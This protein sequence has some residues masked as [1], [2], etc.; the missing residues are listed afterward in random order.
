MDAKRIGFVSTRLAG[1]DGVS[2]ETDK[3]SEIFEE[4]GHECYYMAGE[5]DTHPDRSF[6]VP[7]CHFMHPEIVSLYRACFDHDVRSPATTLE[8]ERIKHLLKGRL[9]AFVERFELDLLVPENAVTIPLNLPLGL[10]IAEYA[11]ETGMPMIAHHHDF[12]WERKR[13][14]RNAAWDY[15]NTAFPPHLPSLQHAVLNSS[16]DNQ[17]SLRTGIS[18]HVVPNVMDFA[19]PPVVADDFADD[20]RATL[21]IEPREKLILQP[22]RIVPRKGIEHAIELVHRLRM[23][24]KLVITHAAGDEGD[25]YAERVREYAALLKVAVVFCSDRVGEHRGIDAAGRKT[26]SLGDLYRQC[27]LVTYPSLIEGFGNAF[28]EAV[29]YRR[30]LMVNNYSIYH[31]DIGPKGFRVIFMDDYVSA[32][33]IREAMAVLEDPRIGEEMARENYRLANKFF[34]YEAIAPK[35]RAMLATAFGV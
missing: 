19:D 1:M 26:Y 5:L 12:F 33:T 31:C 17:V 2:L 30:P 35:L 21:G 20:L 27:D 14:T 34:S 3:W 25:E 10:A 32:S 23:P 13:L 28:L 11:I 24:A 15:L 29:Y 18:A 22:T 4:D 9:R 8:I 6:L 16:Q 7:E